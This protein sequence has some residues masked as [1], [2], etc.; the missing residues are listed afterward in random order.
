MRPVIAGRH[1]VLATGHYLAT[2]AGMRILARGGNAVDAGVAAG[3]ALAVLKPHQ[4]SLGGECPSWSTRPKRI[5]WRPSAAREWRRAR[6]LGNGSANTALCPS[7]VTA[8][9]AATVPGAFG[10]WCA[11][12]RAYGRLTLSEV[13]QPAIELADEGFQVYGRLSS[14]I[15]DHA[16]RFRREWPSTAD[17]FLPGGN[18]PET[19]EILRQRAL[20][21]TLTRLAAAGETTGGLGREEAIARAVDLFYRGEIA[22]CI[23]AFAA[24]TRVMDATGEAHAALLTKEDLASYTTRFEAPVCA[25]YRRYRIFK[26]GPWTQGPVFLQQLKLLEG[27]D[28][29]T[30]RPDSADY[31]HLVVEAAKLAFA[32]RERYYGDPDFATVPLQ[33]LLSAAY[34]DGRRR[35]I[36]RQLANNAPLWELEPGDGAAPVAGDTTHLDAADADGLMISATPSG[37]WIPASPLLPELGFA[38]GTRAQMFNLLPEHPN[39]LQPGKRPRTTL[40]PSLAFKD[41]RP[42]MVFGT[43]GGDHQD[44]WTLQ[45]FL[46]VAEFGMGLQEALDAPSFHTEHFPESFYPHRIRSGSVFLEEGFDPATLDR[47]R[48]MGHQVETLPP[49]SNGE[50]CAVRRA[51]DCLEGAA[52]AKTEG[53]AYALGW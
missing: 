16:E 14:S 11:A 44:Q 53:N 49:R 39:N 50:V 31:I 3:F 32:D 46:N 42:W 41:G 21:R 26:C 12:L 29:S 45:F 34:N 2:A 6:P 13:L 25:D 38:L 37:G 28:L 10:A 51:H 9:F 15:S 30:M 24:E 36:D 52:S 4:S 48:E 1:A 33:R 19:G 17:V 18:V 7:P 23:A 20:A 27:F 43:P 5:G 35:M 22:D 8:Y 40:T 47:L